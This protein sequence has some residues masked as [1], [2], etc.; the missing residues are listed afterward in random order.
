MAALAARSPR[1]G[2][3]LRPLPTDRLEI[4]D[5][6][7][8]GRSLFA[9]LPISAGALIETAPVIIVPAAECAQLDHTILHDYYF[10]WDAAGSGAVALGLLSLC[11]HSRR[12]R[13]RVRCNQT[14]QT[15]DLIALAPIAAGEEITINYDCLL[16]FAP[17]D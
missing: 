10:R 14:G 3:T 8:K 5:D 7:T 11:N 9:R 15:L 16:W 12:P 4:R 6:P 1:A 2:G 17:Q 13:A